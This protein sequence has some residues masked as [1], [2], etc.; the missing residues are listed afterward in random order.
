M[1]PKKLEALLETKV[2]LTELDP[3][4]KMLI[5][6]DYG[7]GK[8][9]LACQYGDNILYIDSAT[10]WVS[11][12]NHKEIMDKNIE[13]MA[14]KGLSQLDVL[15][16]AVLEGH[17]KCDTII[18]D[19]GSSMAVKD[20]D[21]VLKARSAKDANK[22]PDVPTRPDFFANTERV[23]RT[24]SRILQLPCNVIILAHVREDKD[25]AKGIVYTRPAFSPKTRQTIVQECHLVGYMT[26]NEVSADGTPEYVRKLQVHPS[27]RITAKTRI[28]GLP[29][30]IENPNLNDMLEGWQK[31]IRPKEDQDEIPKEPDAPISESGSDDETISLEGDE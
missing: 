16:E 10:G 24:I 30:V 28:D 19:E 25:D 26:A 9:I 11:C 27:A 3:F 21:V 20:L 17:I 8:T 7:V 14:Y 13:R 6:G 23:R 22:D 15:A 12:Q 2:P 5:Y 31:K 1:D 18:L 4:V 29:V